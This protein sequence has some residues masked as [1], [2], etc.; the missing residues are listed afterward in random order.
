MDAARRHVVRGY[1]A[2]EVLKHEHGRGLRCAPVFLSA[3]MDAARTVLR[4]S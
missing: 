4:R 1:Q 2:S 3:S